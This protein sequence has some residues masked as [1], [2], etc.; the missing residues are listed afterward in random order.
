M[1]I[2]DEKLFK[3]IGF[4]PLPGKQEEIVNCKE[5]L[6][7][8]AAGVRFGKTTLAAYHA[9]RELLQDNKRI[10][11]VAPTYELTKKVFDN[12][13][14]WITIG[15]P[16]LAGGVKTRPYPKIQTP[17]GSW[18]EGKSAENPVG[19]LGE[20]LDLIIIDEA[21]RVR[22]EIWTDYL[23]SRLISRRGRAIL[24]S[25]PFGKNW[26]YQKYLEA[27]ETNSAF[28]CESRENPYGCPREEWERAKEKL[29][30][31]VFDQDYRAVFLEDSA[32]VFR[33]VRDIVVSGILSD[34]EPG[35]QY[36]V[37]V[38]LGRYEDFTV[39]VVVDKTT[40]NVVYFDR[41]KTIDWNFQKK[42]IVAIAKRYNN[43][44][45]IIDSS[46]VGEPV[47]DE[48]L[49]NGLIVDNFK[50]ST[51]SKKQ[52]ID[53]LSIAIESK[54][55]FIP[56]EEILIDELESFGYQ[57]TKYG[58][59][60][61]SAPEGKHDDCVIALAL[62]VSGLKGKKQVDTIVDVKDQLFPNRKAKILPKHSIYE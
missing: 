36:I 21:S 18:L 32:S 7:V 49:A 40:H 11:I 62:A 56:P 51:Q 46:G 57:L 39:L 38:D 28:R 19:L 27:K 30:Q 33:G 22:P 1:T 25:T 5:R 29:P 13:V 10:W 55:V 17:W 41:F 54:D 59:I 8:V 6:I 15:F 35:K 58:N 45:V 60:I 53:K 4:K 48:L 26:F 23:Y 44:R 2:N 34:S 37:G 3:K 24:I 43:A 50:L 52:L 47:Y 31:R 42:R 61:Y 16:S 9:L 20:E 12:V 14:K